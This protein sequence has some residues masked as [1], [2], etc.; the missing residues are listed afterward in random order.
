MLFKF[1]LEYD[2]RKVQEDR[3]EL[4]G[5]YQ[6]LVCVDA[7]NLLGENTNI[8]RKHTAQIDASKEVGPEVT[9]KE[10]N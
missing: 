10:T 4:N 5:A 7:V 6:H 2:T 9:A 8:T 1:A 3:L